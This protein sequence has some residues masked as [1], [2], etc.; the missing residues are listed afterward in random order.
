LPADQGQLRAQDLHADMQASAAAEAAAGARPQRSVNSRSHKQ[1]AS[2]L[3]PDGVVSPGMTVSVEALTPSAADAA[4]AMAA[5][6]AG[7]PSI[8]VLVPQ[9]P[10]PEIMVSARGSSGGSGGASTSAA[11]A[12]AEQLDLSLLHQRRTQQAQMDGGSSGGLQPEVSVSDRGSR[13]DKGQSSQNAYGYWLA[14]QH[15]QQQQAS[16]QPSSA[17]SLGAGGV[18]L[19]AGHPLTS[20]SLSLSSDAGLPVEEYFTSSGEKIAWRRA[21]I[22]DSDFIYSLSLGQEFMKYGNWGRPHIRKVRFMLAPVS[23]SSTA[24]PLSEHPRLLLDWGSDNLCLEEVTGVVKGKGAGVFAKRYAKDASVPDNCCFTIV[25]PRRTLDL[26]VLSTRTQR[27]QQ[28]RDLLV[29]GLGE[30]TGTR[31]LAN[32]EPAAG[33]ANGHATGGGADAPPIAFRKIAE[34]C[35]MVANAQS[36]AHKQQA[37]Q[38]GS[39]AAVAAAAGM[40]PFVHGGVLGNGVMAAGMSN[41]LQQTAAATPAAAALTS[42]SYNAGALSALHHQQREYSVSTQLP[43]YT[44]NGGSGY[45]VPGTPASVSHSL[46]GP[47][48]GGHGLRSHYSVSPSPPF[49]LHQQHQHQQQQQHSHSS[50][51]QQ[52]HHMLRG[53]ASSPAVTTATTASATP[54]TTSA[55]LLRAAAGG[56]PSYSG[57]ATPKTSVATAAAAAAAAQQAALQ[58]QIHLHQLQLQQLQQR[59]LLAAQQQQ[60]A[61]QAAALSSSQQPQPRVSALEYGGLPPPSF[62]PATPAA[63]TVG[64]GGGVSGSGLDAH[65]NAQFDEHISFRAVSAAAPAAGLSGW[66]RDL[67]HEGVESNP[68]PVCCQHDGCRCTN[69]KSSLRKGQGLQAAAAAN[70]PNCECGHP[71]FVHEDPPAASGA[72]QYISHTRAHNTLVGQHVH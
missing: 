52:S 42:Q 47:P 10:L 1:Q 67:T 38:G 48:A 63:L 66:L 12:A 51:Q 71:I 17:S 23:S 18:P 46:L 5:A 61:Q 53:A 58:Q 25:T 30:I 7:A 26:Q 57:T 24:P 60:Q 22:W 6:S 16:P 33:G 65:N 27:M 39:T 2:E 9:S 44:G 45:S 32:G 36:N 43:L 11:A 29:F 54:M 56:T 28:K 4:A 19:I 20:L 14:Q 68:G 70:V 15:H 59:Q 41:Q 72:G 49:N 64:A 3:G 35:L 69:S 55:T 37:N 21:G 34:A 62:P 50:Q 8:S 13:R 40:A 31:T